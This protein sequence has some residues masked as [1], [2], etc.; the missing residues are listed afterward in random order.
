VEE[1]EEEDGE[2]DKMCVF[3]VLESEG[4]NKYVDKEE[5]EEEEIASGGDVGE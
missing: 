1:C 4:E 3:E 2:A 5:E